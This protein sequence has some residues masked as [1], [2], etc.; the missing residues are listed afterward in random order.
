MRLLKRTMKTTFC[1]F[2]TISMELRYMV[3][4]ISVVR[5]EVKRPRVTE[6]SSNVLN[7]AVDWKYVLEH[8]AVECGKSERD[9]VECGMS[10]RDVL[11]WN[12][13]RLNVTRHRI[14]QGSTST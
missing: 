13:E 1:L 11:R 9:V 5:F 14:H 2:A 3:S 10:G 12:D 8:I 7:C 4:H 6:V